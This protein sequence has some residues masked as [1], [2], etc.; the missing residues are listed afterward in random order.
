MNEGPLFIKQFLRFYPETLG[1]VYDVNIL[2]YQF[3]HK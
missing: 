2:K 3:K 1:T